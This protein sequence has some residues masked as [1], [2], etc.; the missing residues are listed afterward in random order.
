MLKPTLIIINGK[1]CSGKTHLI[2]R[3]SNE[4][5]IP[6]LSRDEIK[7]HL[8]DEMGILDAEWSKKL[9]R[10]S[11][12]LFFHFMEKLFQSQNSFV[13]DCNF[14]PSIHKPKLLKLLK[15]YEFDAVEIYLEADHQILLTRFQERWN[16]GERHRGHA[17]NER[18]AEFSNKLREAL[19]PLA[20]NEKILAI[21]TNNFNTIDYSKIN[22]L[23][24]HK[25]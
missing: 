11:F 3:L 2:K 14:I 13:V 16:S 18:F 7:E 23:L 9:G 22:K 10:V 15:T 17:D 1:P 4:L 12:A 25:S 8:F 21:N 19:P 20:L 5:K 6:C 24:I